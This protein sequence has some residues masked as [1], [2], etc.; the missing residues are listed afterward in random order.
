MVKVEERKR[1][2]IATVSAPPK[3]KT[4]HGIIIICIL[5]AAAAAVVAGWD[6]IVGILP[7]QSNEVHKYMISSSD[8]RRYVPYKN[9]MLS[10]N[11]SGIAAVDTK[12]NEKWRVNQKIDNPLMA[13][14]KGGI[15]LASKGG[16]SVWQ[17][18]EKGE[19]QEFLADAP[20]T[21][22]K[23]GD[24]GY[25]LALMD[26]KNY[27]GGLRVYNK[28]GVPIFHWAA[29]TC[30]LIDASLAPDGR[31]LA[32]SVVELQ[33]LNL[34]GKILLFDITKGEQQYA[35][36]VFSDN[37]VSSLRWADNNRII[38][39]GDK[40]LGVVDR[41]GNERWGFDY[42]G[43]ALNFFDI[44]ENNN[45]VLVTGGG[46]LDRR[47][48]VKSFSLSGTQNGEYQYEGEINNVSASGGKILIS[49][50]Y[51][52]ILVDK[53]G[54][55]RTRKTSEKEIYNAYIYKKGN[56]VFL[57]EGGFAEIFMMK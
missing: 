9:L 39:V 45:L 21:N 56:S 33:D 27:Y 18:S 49:S 4:K 13:V 28:Q 40:K 26:E 34:T 55:E 16:T 29:G 54:K 17:V 25:L 11:K 5:L 37:M 22:I 2:K 46:S 19:I 43:Q 50:M 38:C 1:Y 52:V 24:N 6:A 32:I 48:M 14:S 20:L 36:K 12:G 8:V 51:E 42:G 31:T 15:V 53:R 10:C 3:K 30:N 44:S 35:E 57:D 7:F 23:I 41:Q 47:M